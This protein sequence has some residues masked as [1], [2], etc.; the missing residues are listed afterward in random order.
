MAAEATHQTKNAALQQTV[1]PARSGSMMP[2]EELGN[3]GGGYNNANTAHPY[4]NPNPFTSILLSWLVVMVPFA[5]AVTFGK[6]VGS[7]RQGGVILASMVILF[8]IGLVL[9]PRLRG[10]GQPEVS[11]PGVTQAAT[12]ANIGGNME[13]KETRFGVSASAIEGN[14][15]TATS[16]G[17][18][19][20][21]HES[22]TPAGWRRAA[23]QHPA[24]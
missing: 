4:E 14:S 23:G 17:S 19:N 15:I 12:A 8:V 1:P 7:M 11:Q 20:S 6:W 21:A 18:P 10:P 9:I 13:G 22:Y 2:I 16:T 3:N 24:G 5:F